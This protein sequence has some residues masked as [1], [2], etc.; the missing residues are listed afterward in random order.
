MSP[1]LLIYLLLWAVFR[2]SSC[3]C[4]SATQKMT[5][6]TKIVNNKILLLRES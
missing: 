2:G 1:L 3:S 5:N 6:M 4:A